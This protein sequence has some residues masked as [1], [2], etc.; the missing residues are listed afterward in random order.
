MSDVICEISKQDLITS[1]DS[2]IREQLAHGN[3]Y[4]H[5]TQRFMYMKQCITEGKPITIVDSNSVPE[6]HAECAKTII[7][8]EK[9]ESGYGYCP[10]CAM[11]YTA[12]KGIMRERR[13]DGNDKCELS[14]TYPSKNALNQRP[15]TKGV[16]C[17]I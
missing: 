3:L 2:T 4:S 12:T 16:L 14:H 9:V 7:D 10:I 11:N 8:R 5:F 15:Q 1:I 17:H 6:F 13:I